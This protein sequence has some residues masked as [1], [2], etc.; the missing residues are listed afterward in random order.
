LADVDDTQAT[1][2][3]ID[4]STFACDEY[5]RFRVRNS[6]VLKATAPAVDFGNLSLKVLGELTVE[7]GVMFNGIVDQ[8]QTL[9]RRESLKARCGDH[10]LGRCP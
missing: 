1:G 8:W 5:T 7:P 4:A 3:T 9:Q 10:V 6:M 2:L